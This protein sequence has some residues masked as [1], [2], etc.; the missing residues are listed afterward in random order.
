M[1]D[2]NYTTEH[3]H[4]SSDRFRLCKNSNS[5][6]CKKKE[7]MAKDR[8]VKFCTKKCGDSY[9][10]KIKLEAKQGK[11]KGVEANIIIL[12]S[13]TC[14]NYA[15]TINSSILDAMHFDFKIYDKEDR[16]SVV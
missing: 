14:K 6:D 11:L 7:F 2:I 12:H 15:I 5:F 13:I 4:R 16:K 8:R 10:N 9:H 1:A 3:I